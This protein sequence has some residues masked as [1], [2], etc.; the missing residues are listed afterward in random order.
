M[1]SPIRIL[2]AE[3]L[4]F[5]YGLGAVV[6]YQLLTGQINLDGILRRKD[7]TGQT[8]PE[9]VQLLLATLAAGFRYLSE[10]AKT[11]GASLP[12][13]DSSWLY[14]MGGSSGVYLLQ[15]A[16][17]IYKAAQQQGEQQ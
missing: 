13:I 14:L 7:G 15:K 4:A 10:V 5:L 6:G 12:D 2:H 11:H 8:S 3:A 1:L 9:R 16:W 17:N